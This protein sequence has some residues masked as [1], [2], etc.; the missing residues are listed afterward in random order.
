MKCSQRTHI[1]KIHRLLVT[2]TLLG[3]AGCS[4]TVEEPSESTD[5]GILGELTQEL[6][7]ASG[8]S[9]LW[10]NGIIPVCVDPDTFALDN[11]VYLQ[12][13]SD[14]RSAIEREYETIPGAS[15]NFTGWNVCADAAPGETE[16][17]NSPGL[18]RMV[19][20]D[21]DR[22]GSVR[23][24]LASAPT[25]DRDCGVP[26]VAMR[27]RLGWGNSF[28]ANFDTTALHE[29][30]H[31][32]EGSRFNDPNDD[33][34]DNCIETGTPITGPD[35]DAILSGTYC[36]WN[37]TLSPLDRVGFAYTY[38][39]GGVPLDLAAS[40]GMQFQGGYAV[41]S[42]GPIIAKNGYVTAGVL[43]SVMTNI[44]WSSTCGSTPYPAQGTTTQTIPTRP[45]GTNC[46]LSHTFTDMWNRSRQGTTTVNV[47]SSKHAAMLVS[48][49]L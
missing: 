42:T 39:A 22:S 7:R 3:V 49:V 23:C 19:F 37:A 30:A 1:L 28:G 14:A 47:S 32:L 15:I 24:R 38:P 6:A 11:P 41:P 16:D 13:L 9:T 35:P 40:F 33:D 46:V 10:S 20:L 18:L 45:E 5:A 4:G 27:L 25:V 17:F 8:S 31:A 2:G 26:G 44:Q 29:A 43:A 12:M 21:K 48:T 34:P 36:H